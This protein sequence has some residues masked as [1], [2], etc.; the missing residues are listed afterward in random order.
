MKICD[1]RA[2]NRFLKFVILEIEEFA[3]Y[4]L[5]FIERGRFREKNGSLFVVR[6]VRLSSR[7]SFISRFTHD[8]PLWSRYCP[9]FVH[10][11]EGLRYAF[12]IHL[13]F[14]CS[15]CSVKWSSQFFCLHSQQSSVRSFVLSLFVRVFFC[16]VTFP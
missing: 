13:S 4:F 12:A 3:S 10:F 9:P 6:V 14:V 15:T 1:S 5:G 2:I 16:S 8:K 11:L 7:L